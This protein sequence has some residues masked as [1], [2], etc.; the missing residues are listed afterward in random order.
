MWPSLASLLLGWLS[1]HC[2]YCSIPLS[3]T[4]RKVA[5]TG[6]DV[7]W[8]VLNSSAVTFLCVVTRV[9]EHA[10]P[11]ITV[12]TNGEFQNGRD[13]RISSWQRQQTFLQNVQTGCGAHP[14]ASFRC[15]EY[16]ELYLHS[17]ICVRG[18]VYKDGSILNLRGAQFKKKP[19]SRQKC[20]KKS[21]A[22]LRTHKY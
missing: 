8:A 18:V 5:F 16:M 20:H 10:L 15:Q 21:R 22:I 4:V 11:Y 13:P 9:H 2:P 19:G 14:V 6:A 1:A 3:S 17:S 7:L 12:C